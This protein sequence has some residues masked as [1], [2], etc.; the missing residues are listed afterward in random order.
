[1]NSD[2]DWF[3]AAQKMLPEKSINATKPLSEANR[4]KVT[5]IAVFLTELTEASPYKQLCDSYDE[6]RKYVAHLTESSRTKSPTTIEMREIYHKA[7]NLFSALRAFDDRTKHNLSERYGK[8]SD[9]FTQF[10]AALSYE[11]DNVFAYRLCYQLRNYSQHAGTPITKIES[12]AHL[13]NE[14][15]V[16]F[17]QISIDTRVLLAKYDRWQSKVKKELQQINGV[18]PLDT[19]FKSL[20]RSC[21]RAFSK[22]LISQENEIL[23]SISTLKHII[24]D[25]EED[26]YPIVVGINKKVKKTKKLEGLK[27]QPTRIELARLLEK[28]LKDAHTV[29]D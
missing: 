16:S 23:S 1:M 5:N 19:I 18:I 14:V 29:I 6:Y 8:K 27:I 25:I 20:M 24:G 2:Y 3:I 13:E 7:D 28:T 10:E 22:Y 21:S 4:K 11:F 26:A 15:P 9:Q 17:L 12:S